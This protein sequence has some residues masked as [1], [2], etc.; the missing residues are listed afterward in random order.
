MTELAEA[1]TLFSHGGADRRHART[2]ALQSPSKAMSAATA[3]PSP[4]R[5]DW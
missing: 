1:A 2:L 5:K 4:P 3:A